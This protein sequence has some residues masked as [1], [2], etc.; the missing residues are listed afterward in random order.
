MHATRFSLHVLPGR[1]APRQPVEQAKPAA[2]NR[3]RAAVL[4]NLMG[5]QAGLQACQ[6]LGLW[7]LHG[8]IPWSLRAAPAAGKPARQARTTGN[9]DGVALAGLRPGPHC[10]LLPQRSAQRPHAPLKCVTSWH[11]PPVGCNASVV[12]YG[13][14]AHEWCGRANESAAPPAGGRGRAKW[15]TVG[16]DALLGKLSA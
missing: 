10:S 8:F 16:W 15:W 2:S 9:I 1:M 12:M 3:G 11:R 13:R 4:H 14:H 7:L 6:R 5:M